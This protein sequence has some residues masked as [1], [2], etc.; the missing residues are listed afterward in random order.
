MKRYAIGL[1]FGTLSCRALLLDTGTGEQAATAVAAYAHGVMSGELPDGTVLPDGFALQDAADYLCALAGVCRKLRE[2][3]GEK[4]DAVAALGIGFTSSTVVAADGAGRPLSADPRFAGNPHAY[5]KLWKH[6]GAVREAEEITAYATKP[7][8]GGAL[9]LDLAGGRVSCELA[10]PKILETLRR[11]PEVYQAAQFC[12]AGDFVARSLTGERRFS[13]SFAL[14]KWH[15]TEENGFLPAGFLAGL[16]GRLADLFC[17]KVPRD[18]VG[19]GECY[20][21]LTAEAAARLGLPAGIPVAAP[22]IDSHAALPALSVCGCGEVLMAIGTSTVIQVGCDRFVPVPG[23]LSIAKDGVFSGLYNYEFGQSAV[24]DMFGH[25][26]TTSLP[27]SYTEEAAARGISVHR[28]LRERVEDEPVGASHLLA[29]DWFNGNRS[30]LSDPDLSGAV[31]G[32][33]L[34]T[35]PEQVY[36]ALIEST[37]FGA[38]RILEEVGRH[39]LPVTN[40]RAAGGIARRDPMLMQIYADVLKKEIAVSDCDE[41]GAR[42]AAVLAAAGAGLFSSLREAACALALPETKVYTPRGGE[43][44]AR[45]DE[46]YRLY[47]G[48]HDR[49]GRESDLMHRLRRI[50]EERHNIGEE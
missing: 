48:L 27:A 49:F 6:H 39:G 17:D 4:L 38:R 34:T 33:T 11:A 21:H 37:A 7:G 29:L 24:G 50:G 20:G 13:S 8:A 30:I 25:F 10:L 44:T 45:Y 5:V 18:L 43:V 32:L 46:L 31:I 1:D 28:L 3:A 14:H 22:I 19:V 9:R 47:L 35:R 15:V 12:E 23:A 2:I 36:R 26:V 40:I 42:G 41:T 16:D